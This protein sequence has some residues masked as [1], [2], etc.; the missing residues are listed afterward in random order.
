MCIEFID[1]ITKGKG[2][3][4]VYASYDDLVFSLNNLNENI[5]GYYLISNV[6]LI[7]FFTTLYLK[8]QVKFQLNIFSIGI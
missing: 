2:Y 8:E 3:A 7:M 5:K 4:C 6:G 1:P